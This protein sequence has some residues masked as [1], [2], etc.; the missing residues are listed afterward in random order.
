MPE[1]EKNKEPEKKGPNTPP[2]GE[3]A[4]PPSKDEIAKGRKKVLEN[5][6]KNTLEGISVIA[7]QINELKDSK[8][9]EDA[10]MVI[11]R[12]LDKIATRAHRESIMVSEQEGPRALNPLVEI[13]AINLA[14]HLKSAARDLEAQRALPKIY[15]TLA[16][17]FKELV[18]VAQATQLL[19]SQVGVSGM[20]VQPGTPLVDPDTGKPITETGK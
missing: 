18:K 16:K 17:V 5:W 7:N 12:G 8:R 4:K 10:L 2:P 13:T 15:E 1:P 11:S 14:D 3:Q 6:A 9:P 19:I 20:V